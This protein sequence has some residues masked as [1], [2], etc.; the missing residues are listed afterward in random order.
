MAALQVTQA[1][2]SSRQTTG[3]HGSLEMGQNW[4]PLPSIESEQEELQAE[5]R[6]LLTDL[7]ALQAAPSSSHI[8]YPPI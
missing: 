6:Q 1:D 8:G 2:S 7:G 5:K 3:L 4:A